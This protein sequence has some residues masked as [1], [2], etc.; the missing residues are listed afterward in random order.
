MMLEDR[1]VVLDGLFLVMHI[2]E[3]SI[4]SCAQ[5]AIATALAV[6]G[7]LLVTYGYS[8]VIAVCSTCT[9]TLKSTYLF[10]A[11]MVNSTFEL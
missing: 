3:S 8:I 10:A 5:C 1:D 4:Y 7:L 6:L 11:L 9:R 2:A